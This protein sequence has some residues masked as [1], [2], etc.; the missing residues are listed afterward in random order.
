MLAYIY[1]QSPPGYSLSIGGVT[2]G[3]QLRSRLLSLSIVLNDGGESDQ[4]SLSIDDSQTLTLGRLA[5]PASGKEI[6]VSLGYE[7]HKAVMGLFH[8]DQVS[9]TGSAGSGVISITAVPKLLLDQKSKTWANT[10]IGDIVSEIASEN[11]LKAQVSLGLKSIAID[12]ENQHNETD[13]SFITRL[14]KKYDALAKP[15]GDSLLFLVKGDTKT[16]SGIPLLPTVLTANDIISWQCTLSERTEYGSVVAVWHDFITAE[17]K[18]VIAGSKGEKPVFRLPHLFQ[19]EAEATAAAQTKLNEKT[20]NTSTLN[21]SVVGDPGLVAGGAILLMAV[22]D[23]IDGT[24]VIKSV[25]H[26]LSASGY[27]CTLSAYK[28]A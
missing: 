3:H 22:R 24:W 7:L 12:V 11:T 26:T 15:A 16:A 18:E 2:A 23:K 8:V 20:R 4:L 1:K 17:Q 9:S 14:A 21:L 28:K 5:F 6:D 13:M 27:Q 19:S 10:T 25:T